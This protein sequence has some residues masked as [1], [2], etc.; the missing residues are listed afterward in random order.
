MDKLQ[1]KERKAVIVSY[2]VCEAEKIRNESEFIY[3]RNRFNVSITRGKAKT[4]VFLSEAIAEASI[5]SNIL[6][7]NTPSL[8]KGMDF[9]HG[10]LP[11]MESDHDG[12]VLISEVYPDYAEDVCIK[13]WKK[14][15]NE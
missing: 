13:L 4:I 3:S 1:G 11:F 15:L 6:V 7:N 2:G 5:D 8:R 10:F 9:I 12:E 14:K